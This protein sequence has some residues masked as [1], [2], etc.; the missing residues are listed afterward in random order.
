MWQQVAETASYDPVNKESSCYSAGPGLQ[1]LGRPSVS[2]KD[3]PAVYRKS[4]VDRNTAT[5]TQIL[6]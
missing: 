1:T 4:S 2:L 6:K 3:R 5:E